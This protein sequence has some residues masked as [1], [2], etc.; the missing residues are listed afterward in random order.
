MVNY[1]D[2]F[3]INEINSRIDKE[4]NIPEKLRSIH[5]NILHCFYWYGDELQRIGYTLEYVQN[6]V[7]WPILYSKLLVCNDPWNYVIEKIKK[8]K[9][10]IEQYYKIKNNYN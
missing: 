8:D 10:K 9:D 2:N 4:K 1:P 6:N 5:R 3:D 7:K